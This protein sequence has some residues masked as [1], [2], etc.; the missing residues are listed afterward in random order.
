MDQTQGPVVE[1][2]VGWT[3]PQK[4]KTRESQGI[5]FRILQ[6]IQYDTE[7]SWW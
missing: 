1:W 4:D 2:V 3:Q 7:T 6:L 5:S